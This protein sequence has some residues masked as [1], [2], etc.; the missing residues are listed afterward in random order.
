M[1]KSDSEREETGLTVGYIMV[2]LGAGLG[3]GMGMGERE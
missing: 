3:M 1:G 2:G